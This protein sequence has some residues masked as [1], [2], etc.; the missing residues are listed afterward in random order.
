MIVSNNEIL[1]ICVISA[2]QARTDDQSQ[3]QGRNAASTKA[4]LLSVPNELLLNI[5]LLLLTD[6][7]HT[8]ALTS[9]R[10]HQFPKGRPYQ[11]PP[12]HLLKRVIDTG[13]LAAVRRFLE[14]GLD[15][16]SALPWGGLVPPRQSPVRANVA[17]SP[18]PSRLAMLKHLFEKKRGEGGLSASTSGGLLDGRGTTIGRAEENELRA[19]L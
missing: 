12:V 15:A 1:L 10:L 16:N 2:S 8:L 18:R 19:Y 13:D 3:R 14:G 7:L 17:V 11:S 4:N 6:H 5:S 9:R